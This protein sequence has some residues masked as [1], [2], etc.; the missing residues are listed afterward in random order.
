MYTL[1][2]TRDVL[3]SERSCLNT[4]K[5]IYY[6][7]NRRDEFLS[8]IY[9]ICRPIHSYSACDNLYNWH[10]ENIFYIFLGL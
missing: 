8:N 10:F 9:E 3:L 7:A 4:G 6:A 2:T 5:F 1:Y